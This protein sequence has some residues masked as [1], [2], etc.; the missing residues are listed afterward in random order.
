M[1]P[2]PPEEEDEEDKE[3][4][5]GC[6]NDDA[7]WKEHQ[8]NGYDGDPKVLR[9]LVDCPS[10]TD[11]QTITFL[12]TAVVIAISNQTLDAQPTSARSRRTRGRD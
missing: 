12:S 3:A 11:S 8:D 5:D 2:A 10:A 6:N 1:S 7:K 9:G 4:K